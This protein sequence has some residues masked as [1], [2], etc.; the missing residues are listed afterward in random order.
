MFRFAAAKPIDPN[1]R[2]A[3]ARYFVTQDSFMRIDGIF[4]KSENSSTRV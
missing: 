2:T 3:R 4:Q 1:N